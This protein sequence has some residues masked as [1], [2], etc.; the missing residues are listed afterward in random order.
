MPEHVQAGG[1]QVTHHRLDYDRRAT[2]DGYLTSGMLEAGGVMSQ[3]FY[4]EVVTAEYEIV[5]FIRWSYK[6]GYAVEEDI[7]NAFLAY[8]EDT[9]RDH[10]VRE[11]DPLKQSSHASYMQHKKFVT[12]YSP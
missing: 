7:E 6:N 12:I 2:L 11:Q 9:G 10:Y 1:W 3:L 4:W 8:V 5:H